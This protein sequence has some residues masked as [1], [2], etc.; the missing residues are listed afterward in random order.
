M[1]KRF[2]ATSTGSDAL[3]DDSR[4]RGFIQVLNCW[5][6]NSFSKYSRQESQKIS[7]AGMM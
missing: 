5:A 4:D 2:G 1:T 3:C 7:T 6:L